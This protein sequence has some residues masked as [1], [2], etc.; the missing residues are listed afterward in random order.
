MPVLGLSHFFGSTTDLDRV[1]DFWQGLGFSEI[2][3]HSG[4]LSSN[5]KGF[6]AQSVSS[7]EKVYMEKR[8]SSAKIAVEFLVF[9]PVATKSLPEIAVS[10]LTL[11]INS[12]ED[13]NE[14]HRDLDGNTIIY[15]ASIESIS[16]CWR[17]PEL[18]RARQE[19]ELLGFT[20][21][22][23]K[24]HI[25]QPFSSTCSRST[26]AEEWKL[27]Q[28]FSSA[29]I[30]CLLVQGNSAESVVFRDDPGLLGISFFVHDLDEISK[31]FPFLFT[32]RI[33]TPQGRSWEIGMYQAAGLFF[34]F[35][36]LAV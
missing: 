7:L 23:A 32:D 9:S 28:F 30:T 5:H 25:Q 8:L 11:G 26:I 31:D 33:H 6:R 36:R 14:M 12:P 34:E 29:T 18:A 20:C 4:L 27:E 21:Q 17:T 19:L 15:D 24:E 22:Q 16:F 35:M 1:I 2:F 10:G 13:G 3:R